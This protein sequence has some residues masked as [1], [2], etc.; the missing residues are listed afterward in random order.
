[1]ECCRLF[2][3]IFIVKLKK[4]SG[5]P[6]NVTL[7]MLLVKL[8]GNWNQVAFYLKKFGPKTIA[9]AMELILLFSK[10]KQE[11]MSIIQNNQIS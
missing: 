2:Q 9:K 6:I 7:R 5:Q 8:L 4:K 1:M 11:K 3:R 10:E